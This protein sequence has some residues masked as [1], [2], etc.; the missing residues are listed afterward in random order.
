VLARLPDAPEGTK[1]ISLFI[2]PKVL[3][4]ADGSL[5]ERNDVYCAGI[6][7]KLGINGNPTCTLNYG[8][9]GG[10]TGYL[11]GEPNHGLEYMFI[12]MNAARFSTGVQGLAIADRAYQS[13]LAYAKERLQSREVAGTSRAAAPIIRHPD[14]RRM[15]MSMKSQ[16][17]A[18][19][20]LA[21]VA[22][23][24]LDLSDKHPDAAIRKQHKA[25]IELMIPVVKGWCSETATE[26]CSTAVQVFG[27]MGYIEETGIAQQYRD[28][29]I[30]SI[31]EGTTGIQALDLVGRKLIR[32][33]GTTAG[34]VI[35]QMSKS[36]AE[37]DDADSDVRAIKAQ[38]TRGIEL[39]SE[40]SQYIGMNAMSDLNR[41]FACSVPYLKLW[42]I[43]AGGW[44][45]ARAARISAAKIAAG[46]SDPFYAAKLATARFY[47]DHVLNA[48]LSLHHEIVH[49]S[50]SVMILSEEQ[51]DLD[52]QMLVVA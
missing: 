48:A 41:A 7:H 33:M 24:S 49:G 14:V 4:N 30:V 10:A 38:L 18:M 9:K 43:V 13:A 32:D 39:L 2:V 37:L 17:E 35:K 45:M 51:F 42:G 28:V 23:A 22:A 8:E 29:K 25:F 50:A 26:L 3:V 46:T 20:A 36:A 1:G 5:R 34:A 47:A 15:L 40:A 12:M 21:Y 6:E 16:I 19:R 31:Y 11:V 44:Q 27:G 52:R